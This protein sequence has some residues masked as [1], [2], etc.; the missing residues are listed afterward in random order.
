MH[1]IGLEAAGVEFCERFGVKVDDLMQTSNP[2][3]YSVGDCSSAWQF[4]HMAGTQV[5]L[6]PQLS[7]SLVPPQLRVVLVPPSSVPCASQ[8][9]PSLVPPPCPPPPLVR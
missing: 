9:P 2:D 4:T 1:G 6:P 5:A 8:L 7:L 3:V